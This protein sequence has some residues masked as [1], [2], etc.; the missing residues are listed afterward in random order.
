M[1]IKV[2]LLLFAS[3]QHKARTIEDIESC[4]CNS[5]ESYSVKY[6][7]LLPIDLDHVV[8]DELHWFLRIMGYGC[9]ACECSIAGC[10]VGCQSQ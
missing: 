10:T 7:P 9:S 8:P 1:L 4:A 6:C 2:L 3:K 5:R